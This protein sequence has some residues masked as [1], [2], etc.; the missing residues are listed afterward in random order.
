MKNKSNLSDKAIYLVILLI[1]L[2]VILNVIVLVISI[3]TLNSI[4]SVNNSPPR[5]WDD[6]W[7]ETEFTPGSICDEGPDCSY[8]LDIWPEPSHYHQLVD[9]VQRCQFVHYYECSQAD[10]EGIPV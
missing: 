3:M 10:G 1:S 6:W 8:C 5:S 9:C 7:G 2:I 4:Q